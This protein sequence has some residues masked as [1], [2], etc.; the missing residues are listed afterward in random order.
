MLWS[1]EMPNVHNCDS[2][3]AISPDGRTAAVVVEPDDGKLELDVILLDVDSGQTVASYKMPGYTMTPWGDSTQGGH[4]DIQMSV[5]S[6]ERDLMIYSMDEYPQIMFSPD[7]SRILMGRWGM[8]YDI[9]V[10]DGSF[11]EQMTRYEAV[12]S[13][14]MVDGLVV[15]VSQRF[16]HDAGIHYTS[17]EAYDG[18]LELQWSHEDVIKRGF[19]LAGNTYRY[20]VGAF[21]TW[22]FYDD[23][24]RQVVALLGN[25]M[26]LLDETSGQVVFELTSE[27]PFQDCLIAHARNRERL[28]LTT[29]SGLVMSRNPHESDAGKGGS[30]Y[31]VKLADGTVRYGDLIELDGHVYCSLWMETQKRIVHRFGIAEDVLGSGQLAGVAP[32]VSPDFW[33]TREINWNDSIFMLQEADDLLFY[34]ATT[35]DPVHRIDLFDFEGY[36]S[37][38]RQYAYYAMGEGDDVYF[39]LGSGMWDMPTGLYH[40]NGSETEL[41]TTLEGV[42]MVDRIDFIKG[43]DGGDPLL[44][45]C[46]YIARRDRVMLIDPNDT[47][48][49]PVRASIETPNAVA[50]WSDGQRI[51]VCSQPDG[52][53][54]GAFELYDAAT[55]EAID[56]E[57]SAYQLVNYRQRA[58]AACLSTDGKAFSFICTDGALRCFELSTGKLLWETTQTP[59][60]VQYLGYGI[61]GD[62]LLQDAFG[63]CML[64]SG[65]SGEVLDASPTVLQPI[66][67]AHHRT[68]SNQIQAYYGGLGDLGKSGVA[69]ISMDRDA[70]GPLSVI[71][72]GIYI[73]YDG[74]RYVYHETIT[75]ALRTGRR[76]SLDEMIAA[77]HELVQGHELTD[78]ERHMS[79][80]G[81]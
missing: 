66:R 19:D 1:R 51:I 69:I 22:D 2:A 46:G 65:T 7:G 68:N 73:S 64:V 67:W 72:N 62:L 61:G 10:A 71:S 6:T 42:T 49:D 32:D 9:A 39:L 58:S 52:Q 5:E 26:L 31:D 44:L 24:R 55:G 23:D 35:L 77:G 33:A 8:I 56:C 13:V 74:S 48:G 75:D 50:A 79:Q 30:V 18:S 36:T 17:L 53:E 28:F 45:L 78:A 47:S 80:V 41:I 21:G 57:L 16:D 12:S 40:V 54:V 27:S 11:R 60:A 43:V 14:S 59:A 38:E 37:K 15:V 29:A 34:D 4:Y 20:A 70:F 76:M 63:R 3:L 25:K 81:D